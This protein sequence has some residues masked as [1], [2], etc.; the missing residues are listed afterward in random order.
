M[1]TKFLIVELNLAEVKGNLRQAVEDRLSR[2]GQPL[3]WA[4]T[5]VD[6]FSRMV[7]VRRWLLQPSR[8][9]HA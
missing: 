1:T 4:V 3:R 6:E 2:Q 8:I 7:T 9:H 5:H